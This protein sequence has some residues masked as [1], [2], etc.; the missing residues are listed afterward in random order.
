MAPKESSSKP[1][2]GKAVSDDGEVADPN[3]P[4][5]PL[6]GLKSTWDVPD[7]DNMTTEQFYAAINKR[8]VDIRN[9]LR[10]EAKKGGAQIV[11]D[12]MAGLGRGSSVD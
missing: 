4:F 5:S 12:Y 11:D 1:R 8:N 2:T 9:K 3:D 10:N 7:S 6:H